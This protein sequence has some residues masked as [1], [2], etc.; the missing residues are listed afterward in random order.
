MKS[1]SRL[2]F[3]FS[4]SPKTFTRKNLIN[5]GGIVNPF[6]RRIQIFTIIQNLFRNREKYR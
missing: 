1:K 3:S 6:S 2:S 5:S 4:Y